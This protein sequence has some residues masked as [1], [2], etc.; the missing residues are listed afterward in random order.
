MNTI[1]KFL[2]ILIVDNYFS[3]LEKVQPDWIF[4]PTAHKLFDEAISCKHL[5]DELNAEKLR[6]FIQKQNLFQHVEK[7]ILDLLQDIETSDYYYKYD[8]IPDDMEKNYTS[9][10]IAQHKTHI[11]SRDATD[12][13]VIE[14][15]AKLIQS[16]AKNT[17]E[18]YCHDLEDYIQEYVEKLKKGE[19]DDFSKNIL[20][21]N[22]LHFKKIFKKLYPYP[23]VFFTRPRMGKTAFSINLMI[24]FSQ[25]KY[26]GIFFA[27]SDD[28]IHTLRSKYIAAKSDLSIENIINYEVSDFQKDVLS[29]HVQKRKNLIKVIDKPGL[30]GD[31]IVQ[32][33]ENLML[34]DQYNYIIIDYIQRIGYEKG[35]DR[36]QTIDKFMNMVATVSKKYSIC[37]ILLSQV[38]RHT[39]S[40]NGEVNLSLKDAKESGNIEE[41]ARAVLAING[42]FKENERDFEWLKTTYFPYRQIKLSFNWQSG[43]L[44][45]ESA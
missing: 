31:R 44:L 21:V 9:F 39:E 5:T 12:E 37:V 33:I 32:I 30:S 43:K 10:L 20:E 42:H 17:K 26:K 15:A 25:S 23:Y 41:D 29:V 27:L 19:K 14:S 6:T 3:I 2:K 8:E 45:G 18:T 4:N 24:D 28:T 36:K 16:L 22:Q 38:G 35:Y 13:S 1:N 34:E 40:A 7:G 11:V